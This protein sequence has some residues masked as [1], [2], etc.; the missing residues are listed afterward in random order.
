[1]ELE[2]NRG[3]QFNPPI[4]DAFILVLRSEGNPVA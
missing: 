4:V 2:K 1:M 3:H